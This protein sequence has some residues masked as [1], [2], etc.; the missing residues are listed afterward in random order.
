MKKLPGKSICSQATINHQDRIRTEESL[1]FLLFPLMNF[2]S[3]L[4]F[5]TPYTYQCLELMPFTYPLKKKNLGGKHNKTIKLKKA[6][7]LQI[8]AYKWNSHKTE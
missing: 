4:L 5:S 7:L 2:I 8:L 6:N 3:S 1:T